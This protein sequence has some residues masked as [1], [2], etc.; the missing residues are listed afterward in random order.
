[1]NETPYLCEAKIAVD[2]KMVKQIEDTLADVKSGKIVGITYVA[3]LRGG[4]CELFSWGDWSLKEA[5][6]CFESW[7]HEMFKAD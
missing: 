7:R 1:M 6:F 2:L 4:K 3:T 5:L